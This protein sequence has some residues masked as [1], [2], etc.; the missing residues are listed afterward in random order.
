M[1]DEVKSVKNAEMANKAE[2][3]RG[4]ETL[5]HRFTGIELK[6]G[7]NNL[8]VFKPS[9]VYSVQEKFNKILSQIQLLDSI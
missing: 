8:L 6:Q 7:Q 1:S 9:L 2:N 5:S 4:M 3:Y